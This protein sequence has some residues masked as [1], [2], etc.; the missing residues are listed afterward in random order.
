M[1]ESTDSSVSKRLKRSDISPFSWKESC[2]LCGKKISDSYRF[3]KGDV[4]E[5]STLPLRSRILDVCQR[6]GDE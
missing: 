5:V 2:F 1:K 6:R 4:R 3:D